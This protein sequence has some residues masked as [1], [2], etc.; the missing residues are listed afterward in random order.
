MFHAKYNFK[1][2]AVKS[3]KNTLYI[4]IYYN[5]VYLYIFIFIYIY[6]YLYIYIYIYIY[7]YIYYSRHKEVYKITHKE[8][9]GYNKEHDF[10]QFNSLNNNGI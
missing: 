5:H 1:I 10:T 8:L 2:C 7:V 4:Y 3:L 9:Y 6:I